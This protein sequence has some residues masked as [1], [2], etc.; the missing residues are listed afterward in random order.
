MN[1]REDSALYYTPDD[2]EAPAD[3]SVA[4][5]EVRPGERSYAKLADRQAKEKNR[6]GKRID[7]VDITEPKRMPDRPLGINGNNK[8]GDNPNRNKQHGFFFNA[9]NCI[10]CHACESACSEKNDN[11]AHLAFRSVGYVEGGCFPDY[12]RLNISM[13]CNHCDDPVC[14]KG[15]PTRAYTKHAEYGAVLQDPETCFGCGYCTWVCPYNAPQ[16]D[17]VKG[18]VSKCNMCVDRLEEGL[19][20]ACVSACLGNALDFGVIENIPENREQAKTSI[21]GFPSPEITHPNIRFQQ[22]ATLPDQMARTDSMPIKYDKQEDNEFRPVLDEKAGK[23]RFWNLKKLS[24]RENP[25]V[26]FTLSTQ[27]VIGAFI[28][29]F[30]GP[31]LGLE[32]FIAVKNSSLYVPSLMILSA[33]QMAVLVLSTLH[34]GKPLRFYRGF[35]NLRYSPLSREALAIAVFFAALAGYSVLAFAGL[36]ISHIWLDYLQNTAAA[37]A[38]TSGLAGIYF[39]HKIYRIKARP[40]WDHWQVLSSFTGTL[41]SLGA[42]FTA[43]IAIPALLL[44]NA[45]TS[46]MLTIISLLALT[47]IT[48]EASGLFAHARYLNR[49]N[50]E[51][52]AAHYVQ[53][54]F[55]GKTYLG[56]NMLMA[57]AAL[58]SLLLLVNTGLYGETPAGQLFTGLLIIAI[59]LYA[60]IGRALF[61]VLVIPT[62]MPGAF[63][64]KNKSFEQHARDIGLAEMPQSGVVAN[65]H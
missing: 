9:D 60:V 22:T 57:F 42:V 23:E 65:G 13:A 4:L 24:S 8:V 53:Q 10:G 18:Q 39:M 19:K 56:R 26:I 34:L 38:I 32:S 59:A 41:F 43:L 15:C 46:E 50:S 5:W 25:L 55:F 44:A 20:P 51:G 54:T 63:F 62:T 33:V 7:L 48:L 36:W 40:F 52:A 27:A 21:P 14:L 16:L 12:K 58:S 1:Q 37:V 61:Y 6:Y 64:W 3:P 28:M 45:D 35:N 11:P 29:L 47:G 31:L 17:P 30:L 2:K 49:E